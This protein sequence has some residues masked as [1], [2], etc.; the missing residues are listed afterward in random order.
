MSVN[1]KIS[2]I[3]L[4]RFVLDLPKLPGLSG[5]AADAFD[6]SNE[7]RAL[8]GDIELPSYQPRLFQHLDVEGLASGVALEISPIIHGINRARSGFDRLRSNNDPDPAAL[9][10]GCNLA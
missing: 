4:Q 6:L 5:I 10:M 7:A 1:R 2:T 3:Y 8:L 9:Q